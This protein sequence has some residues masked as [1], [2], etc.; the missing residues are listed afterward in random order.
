LIAGVLDITAAIITTLVRGGRPTRMLQSIASGVL[1]AGSYQGGTKTIA[2]GLMLHFVI[3]LGATA[4][5]YAASRK[6][7]FLVRQAIISGLLYGI[8][9]FFFMNLVVLPL[10]AVP[11][12]VSFGASQ[13]I[14]G[15]IVHMLCVGLPIALVVRHFSR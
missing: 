3:A 4:V 14:T 12:K 10:S 7:R 13:L 8:A 9:V 5:F 6:L 2:L 15:L 11:F 1:G